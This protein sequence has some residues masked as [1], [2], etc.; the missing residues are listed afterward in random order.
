M[1]IKEILYLLLVSQIVFNVSCSKEKEIK[2]VNTKKQIEIPNEEQLKEKVVKLIRYVAGGDSDSVV[3]MLDKKGPI[4]IG[5]GVSWTYEKIKKDF[6][7]KNSSEYNELFNTQRYVEENREYFKK[8]QSIKPL[9]YLY[10]SMKD[11][12]QEALK[13]NIT[14]ILYP[15]RAKWIGGAPWEVYVEITWDGMAD[16]DCSFGFR[17]RMIDNEWLLIRLDFRG[18]C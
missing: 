14:F 6:R 9:P 7:N 13:N 8:I 12:F 16:K 10:L 3:D 15:V 5:D 4:Y 2:F 11:I 18:M 1:K 17:F